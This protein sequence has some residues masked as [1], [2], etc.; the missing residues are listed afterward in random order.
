M[1]TVV[2][3]VLCVLGAST[4]ALAQSA[5]PPEWR[6][7]VG[8]GVMWMGRQPLGDR[9]AT[10]TT[11]SGGA[12]ALFKTSSELTARAGVDG[13]IG[14]R[15]T[16]SLV[17]EGEASYLK[18]QLSIAVSGDSEG[19]AAV[20]AAETVEQFTIG[21]GVRWYVPGRHWS[22]RFAPF[23]TAGGGYLR[24]L[25]EKATLVETGRYYQIGGGVSALLF[26]GGRFHTTGVGVR[27]DVRALIRS[28]GVAFDGGT[29]AS[30]AAGVSAFLRF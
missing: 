6:V 14:V 28:K 5:D 9:T 12:L 18:P 21:G 19:A 11:A 25:H 20:T 13:R 26:R 22:P 27:A 23:A 8:L 15:L 7:D 4:A 3:G 2:L 16:R 30:P 1:R 10:E 24:Q 29:K 17:V